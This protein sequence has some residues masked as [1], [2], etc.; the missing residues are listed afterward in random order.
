MQN[1]IHGL[2]INNRPKKIEYVFWNNPVFR[3]LLADRLATVGVAIFGLFLV[4]AILADVIAPY[5]P[6]EV[7]NDPVTGTPAFF[8][9]PSTRHLFGTTNLARDVFS[10]VIY[11]SR[12][13]ISV[14]FVS[15]IVVT[16]VGSSVGLL[17]GYLG[18][19]VDNF[20]MR[21]VDMA[22]SIP[23]EPFAV[24]LVGLLQPNIIN[25]I[26][27]MA[28]LMW[29]SPAR[30]IRAEVLS[31][32]QRPFVKAAK[33]AGASDFR[34]MYRHIAPNILPIVLLYIPITVGWAIIAEAS[35]SFLGFGDPR[36]IS[37]GGML[38]LAFT[39]GATRLAWWWTLAPGISIVL[40]VISV[41]FISRALE[42]LANPT[43]WD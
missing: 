38:Q 39:S 40:L 34:I 11:G 41:F 4:V 20:L 12:V 1:W 13:A 23:F 6:R 2:R 30:V 43:L 14:G 29:R 19:R 36:L 21:L 18:G 35:V 26:L 22:Y 37:W 17:A 3:A 16:L 24:L 42:S 27:A 8:S 15:A 7:V 33:V 28:L 32:A 10:Q 31:L 9:S 5:G 25:L